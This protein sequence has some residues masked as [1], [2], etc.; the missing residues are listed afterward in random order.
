[1]ETNINEIEKGY[2]EMWESLKNVIDKLFNR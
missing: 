1:M 2:T